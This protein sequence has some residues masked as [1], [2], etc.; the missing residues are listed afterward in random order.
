[1][2]Q[3][4]SIAIIAMPSQMQIQTK[5]NKNMLLK[6][7]SSSK[8]QTQLTKKNLLLRLKKLISKF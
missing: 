5:Q 1:M 8:L 3:K 4:E 6:R 2:I 7:A